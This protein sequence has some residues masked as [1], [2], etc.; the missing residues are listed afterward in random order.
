MSKNNDYDRNFKTNRCTSG[1]L[2]YLHICGGNFCNLFPFKFKNIKCWNPSARKKWIPA[3]FKDYFWVIIRLGAASLLTCFSGGHSSVSQQG[4]DVKKNL[5]LSFRSTQSKLGTR[6]EY[7]GKWRQSTWY[8][9]SADWSIKNM[10][11]WSRC[12]KQDL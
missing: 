7:L 11:P 3:R 10:A 9:P 1:I 4:G 2:T 6:K 8:W 5:T 12:Y